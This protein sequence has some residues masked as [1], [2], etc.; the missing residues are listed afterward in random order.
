MSLTRRLFHLTLALIFIFS[1]V[2]V[3]GLHPTASVQAASGWVKSP[4]TLPNQKYVL[5]STV[6]KDGS[7]YKMWYTY[8]KMSSSLE[9]LFGQLK[10]LHLDSLVTDLQNYNFNAFFNHLT[11]LNQDISTLRALFGGIAGTIGYATSTDGMN[12]TVQNAN[13]LQGMSGGIWTSVGFPAVIKVDDTHYKMW[14]T[15]LETSLTQTQIQTLFTNLGVP[16]QRRIA[17]DTLLNSTKT[18]IGYATSTNG[19]SWTVENPTALV[20][21][22]GAWDVFNSVMTPSV[23]YEGGS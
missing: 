8:V 4:I 20:G 3:I 11:D 10:G 18:V 17:L 23:M 19:S 6:I 13:A 12:W 1:L 15:R 7:T 5:D 21:T 14:F 16:S 2:P 22:G 9:A